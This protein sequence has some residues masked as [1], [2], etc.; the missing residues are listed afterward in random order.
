MH[1]SRARVDR[2]HRTELLDRC[3]QVLNG[4]W[5]SRTY[6]SQLADGVFRSFRAAQ[7][8]ARPARQVTSA[9]QELG[10]S[11]P[12][13]GHFHVDRLCTDSDLHL[14]NLVGATDQAFA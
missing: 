1:A 8:A 11:L 6:L 9:V 7:T 5:R 10:K 4:R 3:V 2:L 12:R 14:A 13:N